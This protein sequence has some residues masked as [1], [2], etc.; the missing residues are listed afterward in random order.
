VTEREKP[1]WLHSTRKEMDFAAPGLCSIN[2]C[3]CT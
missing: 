2:I 3:C 1:R